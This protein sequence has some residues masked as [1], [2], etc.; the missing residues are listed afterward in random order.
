MSL[1]P[2]PAAM[3]C[4]MDKPELHMV[5]WQQECVLPPK[6]RGFH[7]IN[8]EIETILKAQSPIDIGMA[9]LFLQHTSASLTISENACRDVRLDLETYFNT[10]VPEHRHYRHS[11]EGD[12]DM[13][14]HIKNVLLGVN[15]SIPIHKNRLQLGQW[16]G[17]YLCEHRDHALSRR[18]LITAHGQTH[19]A[20]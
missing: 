5:Y 1:H 19:N 7:L 16:Q 13:P 12:D 8:K 6:T 3:A 2:Q 15:L 4:G 9:H 20:R 10:A 11:V 14:A 17:I 18:I